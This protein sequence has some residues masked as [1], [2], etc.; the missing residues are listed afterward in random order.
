MYLQLG[1]LAVTAVA[2]F[3]LNKPDPQ[4]LSKQIDSRIN[5]R[6]TTVSV[7]PAPLADDATFARR[8]YLLLVGRVA[9]TSEV[10]AFLE[11]KDPKK[12]DKLVVKLMKSPG[13]TNHFNTVWRNWLIP[14]AATR[15]EIMY[16][17]PQFDNWIRPKLKNN[18]PFDQIVRELITTPVA[19]QNPNQ[20]FD[21]YGGGGVPSPL[22]WYYAKDAKPENLAAAVT[23]QFLGVQLECAQ[24]HNHPFAKWSRTQ[25]WGMAA[26]FGGIQSTQPDQPYFSPLREVFDRRELA[27]PNS[28][29]DEVIQA[30]FLDDS[31]PEWKAKTSSRVALADWMTKPGNPFFAR[32]TVNRMW[33]YVFGVGIVEPVDDFTDENKPSHPELL[34]ELAKAFEKSGYDQQY[35]LRAI[36]ATDA[37][38]RSSAQTEPGQSDARLLARFPVQ[39][40]TPEQLYDSLATVVMA[41]PEQNVMFAFQNPQSPRRM[42]LEKFA[43]TGKKTESQTSILQALTLM[44]GQTV[45]EATQS[46]GGKLIASV[47][48]I[49][50]LTDAERVDAIYLAALG[51]KPTAEE[52]VRVEKHLKTGL[53]WGKTR[54]YGDLLWA[55]L[56]STEFRTNH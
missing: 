43:L 32:A 56:N 1:V 50:G 54:R 8:T 3:G 12:R 44:N 34:H 48:E 45:A 4:H 31:E 52:R 2:A 35:L 21:P 55:L 42:F 19:P 17:M 30:T 13:Y 24:C 16:L 41:D 36:M 29:S 27:I 28:N 49:P 38:Q 46:D 47:I 15:Y 51:R 18:V 11:D 53:L 37:Y 22:P 6:L 26:F 39:G 10:H 9:L 7:K 25:F 5:E 20:G 14:E 40:L 23:R 33:A